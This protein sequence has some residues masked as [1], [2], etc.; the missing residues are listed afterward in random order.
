MNKNTYNMRHI[1]EKGGYLHLIC[2]CMF[3]GK[4]S[5]LVRHRKRH[6]I[7]RK[8]C[9]LV[10][11][12]GD[13]RYDRK[14]DGVGAQGVLRTHDQVE[15][16]RAVIC[17]R[18]GELFEGEKKDLVSEADVVCIDEIQF[19]P[20]NVLGCQ[21][22]VALGKV[23]IASGLF[24]DFQRR[25]F[26]GMAELV[27]LS[28]SPEFLTAIC[29]DCCLDNATCSYRLTTEKSQVVIGGAEMYIPLCQIC[30]NQREGVV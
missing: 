1:G 29:H 11:F 9:L 6:E 18:L 4:S 10:K 13:T 14:E 28:D 25:P 16:Q 19:Y 30:Y 2:G 21:K 8:K 7:A 12:A 17:G 15:G 22:L 20:D 26:P 27:A 24:A 5:S 3:S 23:V